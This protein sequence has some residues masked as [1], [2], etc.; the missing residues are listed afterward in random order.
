MVALDIINS[1]T[2]AKYEAGIE[3]IACPRYVPRVSPMGQIPSVDVRYANPLPS[4]GNTL[5][6]AA[7]S[8]LTHFAH[9]AHP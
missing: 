6:W 8:P 3:G 4:P 1:T 9:S 2:R 7:V 5:V